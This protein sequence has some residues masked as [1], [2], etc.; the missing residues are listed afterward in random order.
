[1][2][3]GESVLV[4][5]KGQVGLG[6]EHSGVALVLQVEQNTEEPRAEGAGRG[7]RKRAETL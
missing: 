5:W 7:R 2:R 1:M 4:Y 6:T 3:E